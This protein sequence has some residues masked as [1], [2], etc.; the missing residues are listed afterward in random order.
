MFERLAVFGVGLLGGSL[1]LICKQRGLVRE[2]IGV[3]RNAERLT[4]AVS[5]GAIDRFTLDPAEAYGQSDLIILCAPVQTILNVLP[6]V[7][8]A[9][10]SGALVTDVG[11]SKASIAEAARTAFKDAS[12]VFIGSHPM[13]GSEQ[14]GVVNARADLYEEAACYV[15]PEEDL[16]DCEAVGRLQKFWEALGCAVTIMDPQQHDRMVAALS[17]LPHAL[18]VALIDSLKSEGIPREMIRDLAG[19]GLLD[20]TRIAAGSTDMWRDIFMENRTEVIKAL[21][22]FAVTLGNFQSALF[23]CDA[24]RLEEILDDARELRQ[25][26]GAPKNQE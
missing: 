16:T 19:P 9:A 21:N 7:A 1:G 12:A 20:T 2:V 3:G 5:L 23:D 17:H 26:I 18:A 15:T 13:A 11:S 4:E 24:A 25:F 6:V 22:R 8:R 14:T 10:P